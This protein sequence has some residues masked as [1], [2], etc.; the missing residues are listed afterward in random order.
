M[1]PAMALWIWMLMSPQMAHQIMFGVVERPS[2]R[3]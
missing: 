1:H 3:H 2:H